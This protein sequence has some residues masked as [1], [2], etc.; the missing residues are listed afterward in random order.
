MI[1]TKYSKILVGV[2]GSKESMNAA[3]HAMGLARKDNAELICLTALQLPS[4]YG[5]SAIEA[6]QE[7][8]KKDR[9]EREEWIS[10]IV[11]TA[12]ENKVKIQDKI[13]ESPMS[14]DGAIVNYA[15]KENVDLIVVGTRGRTGFAKK[16]LG[17]VA[18][19]VVIHASC[20][21]IVVK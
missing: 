4:F 13:V 7:W 18:L 15:D 14:A 1:E 2:D 10:T 9:L 21:V 3:N 6:P 12:N 19:G 20:P 11:Q 5:W 17:S 16:L 8:Q